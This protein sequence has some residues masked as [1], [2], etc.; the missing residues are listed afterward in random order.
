METIILE[1]PWTFRTIERT[2]DFAAGTHSVDAEVHAAALAAG[3]TKESGNGG[4]N[5]GKGT[6]G[7]PDGL[8]G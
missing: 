3:V 8:E 7:D 1:S 4:R 2:I 5:S 6:K